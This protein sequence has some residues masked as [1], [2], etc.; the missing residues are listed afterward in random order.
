M[1]ML[2]ARPIGQGGRSRYL[3]EVQVDY[4]LW[5]MS[6]KGGAVRPKAAG[7][8]LDVPR[9]ASV[10][11]LRDWNSMRRYAHWRGR[12]DRHIG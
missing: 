10:S 5:R 7:H 4:A 2:P 6:F 11:G 1:L 9:V 3:A 8:V 12:G